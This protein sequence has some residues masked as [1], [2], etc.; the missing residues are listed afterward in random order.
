[1]DANSK[2]PKTFVNAGA[3]PTIL[4][5]ASTKTAIDNASN[6]HKWQLCQLR[7]L[8]MAEPIV[9]ES[10]RR[11]TD[12]ATFCCELGIELLTGRN[13][14]IRGQLAT[15]GCPIVGDPLYGKPQPTALRM[16]LQC[17]ELSF[18]VPVSMDLQTTRKTR[19]SPR[20][21]QQL[22]TMTAVSKD[23]NASIAE[24]LGQLKFRLDSAWWRLD[25]V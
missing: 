25:E 17:C 2:A 9:D 18:P 22:E 10:L 19:R 16:A 23:H 20:K 1:M 5:A 24:S 6:N 8:S 15:L 7:I 14:Q 12:A 11:R 13:H 21:Q 4:D 3:L